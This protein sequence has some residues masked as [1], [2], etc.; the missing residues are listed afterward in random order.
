M[1]VQYKDY[2]QTLG[3]P[4][5]A[6]DADIKKAFRRLAREHHPDV[7]KDKKKAEEKFKEINEAYEVLGDSDKRKRYDELGANWQSGAEFR[8]P[9]G[10]EQSGGA[11]GGRRTGTEGFEFHFGGTGFS[12]FFEQMFGGAG[13]GG[14][15]SA[16][17]ESDF[18]ERGRD[19]EG[20]ILVTLEEAMNGSVRPVSV[21]HNAPCRH[22]G[23]S[24]RV[25]GR[26][27]RDCAG[28][29]QM[30]ETETYQVKVPPGVTE[31]QKL[32]LPGR[33]EAGSSG[34]G[35][36]DLFLRVRMARHP[37]FDVDGH[38]LVHEVELAPWEAVLGSSVEVPTLDGKVSIRIPAGT[39]AGQKLRV[40]G[41]GLPERGGARGDLIVVTRVEVPAQVTE[42]ER[43]LWE[44]LARDSH[45]KPRG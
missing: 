21:R 43:R 9:P 29:G 25:M 34:G 5:S 27:C 14:R 19:I 38:N 33:G 41:R 3:V 18:A 16:F 1:A 37:D 45:F 10:W 6:S 40:R 35:A 13:R 39:Q 7:A 24:G 26:A 23:G 2:Y 36:G 20:D 42:T 31:G 32:R 4:R 12:D 17:T 15:G 8:P 44:Q 22:C 30:Q 28:S 11:R